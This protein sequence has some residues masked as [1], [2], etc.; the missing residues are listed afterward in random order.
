[1]LYAVFWVIHRHLNFMCQHFGTQSVRSSQEG[2]YDDGT[3]R[4]L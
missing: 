4:V 1:M 3:D 2:S